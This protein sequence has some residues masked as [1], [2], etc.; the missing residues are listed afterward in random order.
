MHPWTSPTKPTENIP[1]QSRKSPRRR[2]EFGSLVLSE[3]RH[4]CGNTLAP[5]L[6]ASS[7]S[8]N[9]RVPYALLLRQS[10]EFELGCCHC[11]ASRIHRET[12]AAENVLI[13]FRTQM[14]DK[15]I[16]PKL[17]ID[18]YAAGRHNVFQ[19][20]GRAEFKIGPRHQ[21]LRDN[22]YNIPRT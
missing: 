2:N 19:R 5:R 16:T 17:L 11:H 6:P 3:P 10:Q 8:R 21:L 14:H 4:S 22:Y 18:A 7:A 13:A 15:N 9:C 1:W 20:K 12:S